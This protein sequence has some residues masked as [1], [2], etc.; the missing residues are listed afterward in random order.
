MEEES[1]PIRSDAYF[2]DDFS[3]L[4]RDAND[5]VARGLIGL[6]V[7]CGAHCPALKIVT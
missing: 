1:S 5:E 2:R 6:A 3:K 7:R 4:I